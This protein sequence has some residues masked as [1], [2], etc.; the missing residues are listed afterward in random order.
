MLHSTVFFSPKNHAEMK[1]GP[2][3]QTQLTAWVPIPAHLQ[4]PQTG[5]LAWRI[6]AI[7]LLTEEVDSPVGFNRV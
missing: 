2:V 4:P 1:E 5:G 6:Q 7:C 3:N